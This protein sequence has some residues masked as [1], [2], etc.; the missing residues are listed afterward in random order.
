MVSK[1]KDPLFVRGWD[2]HHL[3]RLVMPISDGTDPHTHDGYL[4]N[5]K[6]DR[7][8]RSLHPCDISLS[9]IPVPALGKDKKR[10]TAR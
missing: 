7:D 3:A 10:T 6:P 8:F 1:K 4:Y 2:C 5:P 9:H